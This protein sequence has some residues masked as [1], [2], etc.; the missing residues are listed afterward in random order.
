M[1]NIGKKEEFPT[2]FKLRHTLHAHE[3]INRIA[4]SPDGKTLA[5][6]S[7][8]ETIQIWD[9]K[10]QEVQH[11]SGGNFNFYSGPRCQD[12]KDAFVKIQNP[13]SLLAKTS[14]GQESFMPL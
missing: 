9:V 10:K 8:S 7:K 14:E 13:P 12:K 11:L 4:W 1:L 3:E 6:G 2:G 5:C